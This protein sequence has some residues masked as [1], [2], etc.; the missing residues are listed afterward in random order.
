MWIELVSASLSLPLPL[1]ITS[2]G[3]CAT[4]VTHNDAVVVSTQGIAPQ[5]LQG[6]LVR[7]RQGLVVSRCA[8]ETK[9]EDLEESALHAGI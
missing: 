9:G 1:Y 2:T 5:S 7:L 3:M 8:G 4:W 6:V